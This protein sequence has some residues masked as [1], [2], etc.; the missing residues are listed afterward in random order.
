GIGAPAIAAATPAAPA[1]RSVATMLRRSTSSAT[2]AAAQTPYCHACESAPASGI[3]A[4]T[5]A[6]TAAGAAPAR[7]ALARASASRRSK[8]RAPSSTNANDG[9]NATRLASSAPG[10][11]RSGVADRG[12]RVRD[13]A[14]SDLAKRY[15]AE[16]LPVRH[17]AACARGV[18]LHQGHDYEP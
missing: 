1:R 9:A 11:P 16:E 13:R 3:A 2:A 5:I 12:D 6:P 7:N 18:G 15:R 14:G 8:W 4:P 10:Y 17:P